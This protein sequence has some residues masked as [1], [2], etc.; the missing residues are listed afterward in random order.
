MPRSSFPC[1]FRKRQGKPP[2]RQGILLLAEPLK[3]LG[4][5]GKKAQNRKEFLEKEKGKEI[6]K[7]KE[8]KIRVGEEK[9]T[10]VSQCF[11]CVFLT[12]RGPL[13]SHDSNP[14]P[15]RSRI[16]RYNATKISRGRLLPYKAHER[17][18]WKK[19]VKSIAFWGS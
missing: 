12:F 8:R 10:C 14:Y 6:Q 13:A 11:L 1:R 3:S 2:K 19:K 7:G 5:K 18:Q 15:H 16:A 9:W 17:L 4:K